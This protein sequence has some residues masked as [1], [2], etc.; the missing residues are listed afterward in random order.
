MVMWM[1]Q[2]VKRWLL[3]VLIATPLT[4]FSGGAGAAEARLL[5][6][7]ATPLALEELMGRY[8]V[9]SAEKYRGGLTTPVQAEARV[10]GEVVLTAEVFSIDGRESPQPRYSIECLEVS[11]AEGEVPTGRER[12]LGTFHGYGTERAVVWELTVETGDSGALLAAFEVVPSG[13]G[14]ELWRLY[15][16]WIY[17][18][19][20][21]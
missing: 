18:L 4:G 13:D 15:D 3:L 8:A 5:C 6:G 17:V 21:R 2:H 10:G 7:R 19:A 16:G 1:R 14:V 20:A 12:M 11:H 9:S